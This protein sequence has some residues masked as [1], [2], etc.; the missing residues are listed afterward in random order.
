[1]ISKIIFNQ[2]TFNNLDYKKFDKFISKKGFFV[3]PAGPALATIKNSNNYFK[4]M[5]KADL[6]FF[7]SGF[8]VLLLKI[9]KNISVNKFSGFKFL[10]LFFIYIKKK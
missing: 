10:N 5:Q 8:F 7:D 9:F 3:F 6:V 2:I 4:A 1:M